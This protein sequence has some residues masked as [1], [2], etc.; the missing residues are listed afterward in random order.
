MTQD[1]LLMDNHDGYCELLMVA[2]DYEF[3]ILGGNLC[4]DLKTYISRSLDT[5]LLS[6]S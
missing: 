5:R 1:D 4:I 3:W 6:G 2:G